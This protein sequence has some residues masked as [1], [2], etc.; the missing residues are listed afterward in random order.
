MNPL[1]LGCVGKGSGQLLSHDEGKG[2]CGRKRTRR[3]L[4]S[5]VGT[6]ADPCAGSTPLPTLFYTSFVDLDSGNGR[7]STKVMSSLTFLPSHS[8]LL[9]RVGV[10]RESPACDL[11]SM[12]F[13]T[14]VRRQKAEGA[15]SLQQNSLDW[16]LIVSCPGDDPT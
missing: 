2:Q 4:H 16:A 12:T 9:G 6:G 5:V 8:G 13:P 11:D 7:A 3:E 1:I 14:E 10:E 15:P